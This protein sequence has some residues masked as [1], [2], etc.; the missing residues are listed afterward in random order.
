VHNGTRVAESFLLLG[1]LTGND[2]S[3]GGYICT[4]CHVK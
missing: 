1:K 3:T 2:R 4:Q